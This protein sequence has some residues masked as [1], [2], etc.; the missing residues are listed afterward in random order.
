MSEE[1]KNRATVGLF[2][3]V[4]NENKMLAIGEWSVIEI[5]DLSI[6]LL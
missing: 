2:V 4:A 5:A 1:A 3:K 6:V